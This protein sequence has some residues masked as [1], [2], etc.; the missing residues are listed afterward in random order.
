MA[1]AVIALMTLIAAGY[2]IR[3]KAGSHTATASDLSAM[4]EPGAPVATASGAA[5][6]VVCGARATGRYRRLRDWP[7]TRNA[8]L[9][10]HRDD[11]RRRT[12]NG[13]SLQGRRGRTTRRASDRNRSASVLGVA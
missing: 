3:T 11:A 12:N 13:N 5:I 1:R 6:T 10:R 9:H 8:D 4:K 2:Y 7:G